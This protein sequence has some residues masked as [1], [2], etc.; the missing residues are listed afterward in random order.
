MVLQQPTGPDGHDGAIRGRGTMVNVP[1]PYQSSGWSTTTT[2]KSSVAVLVIDRVAMRP[3][4]VL[5]GRAERNLTAELLPGE[6]CSRFQ[7]CCNS[8]RPS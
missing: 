5:Q 1:P 6:P 4:V 3:A 7:L 8:R 2:K